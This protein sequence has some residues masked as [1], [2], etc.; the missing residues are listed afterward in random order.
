[1]PNQVPEPNPLPPSEASNADALLA[2][3]VECSDDAIISKTLDGRITSWNAAA[4]NLFGYKAS[5]AIGRSIEFIIPPERRSEEAEILARIR[6]GE[7][8]EHFE[9]VRVA[10]D[11]RDLSIALTISPL[12]DR[13]GRVI[14]ASKIVRDITI[15]A[16]SQQALRDSESRYR[17]VIQTAVDGIITVDQTGSIESV[18]SAAEILFRGTAHELLGTN[19]RDLMPAAEPGKP[20]IDLAGLLQAG[21][22]GHDFVGR[23]RDGTTFPMDLAVSEWSLRGRRVFTAVVRDI[24][25]RK[26]AETRQRLM[27]DELDHRVKNTLSAVLSLATQTFST[28][29]SYEQF[30]TAFTGR[31]RA[32]AQTHSALARGKWDGVWLDEIA[33]LVLAPYRDSSGMRVK[34]KGPPVQLGARAAMPLTLTLHELA[35]NAAKYGA[36]S[37]QNGRL[38]LSWQP[39]GDTTVIEW[40]ERGGPSVRQ[41]ERTGSGTFIMEGL[42]RYELRG[43]LELRYEPAGVSCT[44]VVPPPL[45]QIKATTLRH[46]T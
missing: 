40:K 29:D 42:I 43:T 22:V 15:Q 30:Q 34:L 31:V 9:T 14:G 17:A 16:A 19:F 6:R 27:A 45:P 39:T 28:S 25:E 8:I 36:L 41:P 20:G 13:T 44:I 1:M 21:T 37:S 2:C 23:R 3:I 32:M 4:E 5:E 11:G 26:A 12:R 33:S 10:K 24:S 35:T 7:R 46:A 18:N 38:E